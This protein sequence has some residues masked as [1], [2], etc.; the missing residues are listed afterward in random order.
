MYFLFL[1]YLHNSLI[2]RVSYFFP[3]KSKQKQPK[4][5]LHKIQFRDQGQLVKEKKNMIKTFE[6]LVPEYDIAIRDRRKYNSLMNGLLIDWF[7]NQKNVQEN[8]FDLTVAS[9]F[10]NGK[11][12]KFSYSILK[13]NVSPNDTEDFWFEALN[14][15]ED[16]D[17]RTIHEIF[18]FF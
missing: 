17:W 16:L 7:Y 8:I 11:I 5:K 15:D 3:L 9:L 4:V 12:T 18:F 14:V 1:M 6:D 13:E 2:P 10:D